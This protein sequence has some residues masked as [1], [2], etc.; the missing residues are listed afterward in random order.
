MSERKKVPF[1]FDEFLDI[2]DEVESLRVKVDN[3][4]AENEA[5]KYE[6]ASWKEKYENEVQYREDNYE[7]VSE[8]NMYGLR[9]S[10]FH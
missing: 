2:E 8:M 1:P 3:L 7:R 10:D 9:E 5:L 4:E 6:V